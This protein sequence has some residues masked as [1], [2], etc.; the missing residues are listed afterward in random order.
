MAEQPLMSGLGVRLQVIFVAFV[1][2]FCVYR[3]HQKHVNF[4]L[5]ANDPIGSN[6]IPGFFLH[7]SH[8]EPRTLRRIPSRQFTA[9][10]SVEV[11][12]GSPSRTPRR[13]PARGLTTFSSTEAASGS[14]TL[15]YDTKWKCKG[16]RLRRISI[17][18][19]NSLPTPSSDNLLVCGSCSSPEAMSI[20]SPRVIPAPILAE[21]PSDTP[22]TC[23]DLEPPV[24]PTPSTPSLDLGSPPVTPQLID[25]A[26]GAVF[27]QVTH[28]RHLC[29]SSALCAC[30]LQTPAGW[31]QH[32]NRRRSTTPRE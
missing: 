24:S 17:R 3:R 16:P 31:R 23:P 30:N 6:A 11:P 7:A 29:S 1:I 15:V 8:Q 22:P 19:P 5:G 21:T 13:I 4:D 14:E 9:P 26:S 18:I 32:I 25:R 20:F 12:T 2:V 28:V 27:E 10:S